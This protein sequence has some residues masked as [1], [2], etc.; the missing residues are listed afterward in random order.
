MPGEESPVVAA[1]ERDGASH[2][3]IR[4]SMDEF[5]EVKRD[6]PPRPANDLSTLAPEK[7]EGGDDKPP[8]PAKPETKPESKPEETAAPEEKTGTQPETKRPGF[9]PKG[10]EVKTPEVKT[11]TQP[12]EK[13]FEPTGHEDI[14]KIQ[15][16]PNSRPE[17]KS[18]MGQL[19]GLLVAD[20]ATLKAVR[21]ENETLKAEVAKFRSNPQEILKDPEITERLKRADEIIR[22]GNIQQSS[23]YLNNYA[24]PIKQKF[25]TL[26]DDIVLALGDNEKHRA[27]ADQIKAVGPDKLSKEWWD[28]Q[29]KEIKDEDERDE[30]RA[31]VRDITKLRKDRDRYLKEMGSDEKRWTDYQKQQFDS[32]YANYAKEVQEKHVPELKK[33]LGI[34]SWA[35]VRDPAT[36]KNDKERA[37]IETHNSAINEFQN[38]FKTMIGEIHSPQPRAHTKIIMLAIKGTRADGEIKTLNG[39]LSE[40]NEKIKVLEG[41]LDKAHKV[42]KTAE[43]ST[44]A[45]T[46][47]PKENGTQNLVRR[48]GETSAAQTVRVMNE[49]FER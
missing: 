24:K 48:K 45:A 15:L 4:S 22:A 23:E 46:P 3:E 36:A 47:V 37:E 12:A 29:Y 28:S 13:D 1:P 2:Q 34:E 17:V 5:F 6:T 42:R 30:I 21:E 32:Y 7:V 11:E 14:D 25:D 43:S 10:P 31:A 49:Y 9:S 44:P 35:N 8:E 20:R 40:A 26:I 38:Q 41:Q 39:Q 33:E 18:Q 27:W 16:R 19:R